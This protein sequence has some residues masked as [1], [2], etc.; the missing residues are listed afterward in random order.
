MGT[1]FNGWRRTI[2]IR[3]NSD[4]GA[5]VSR[6]GA[7]N[8]DADWL[9]SSIRSYDGSPTA[10][11]DF[12]GFRVASVPEPSSTILVLNAGLFPLFRRRRRASPLSII[13]F[14]LLIPL[15]MKTRKAL[16]LALTF[17]LT[18][19]AVDA[20]TTTYAYVGHPFTAYTNFDGSGINNV[21]GLLSTT[22]HITATVV[23]YNP[24]APSFFQGV[25][26]ISWSIS[27]ASRPSPRQTHSCRL[28]ILIPTATTTSSS[29]KC[30][31]KIIRTQEL[32]LRRPTET[33]LTRQ[34]S[35]TPL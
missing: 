21:S 13:Q 9:Q 17:T 6:G 31:W 22:Q 4:D 18:S 2:M 14:H 8:Y 12:L 34:G 35:T 1:C 32:Q 5:H 23:L 11:G 20:Q 24:L 28:S 30:M 10:A 15:D 7:W 33:P 26:P 3:T 27:M 29:G 19:S 16:V 25:S